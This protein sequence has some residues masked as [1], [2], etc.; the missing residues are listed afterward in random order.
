MRILKTLFVA[1]LLSFAA[2]AGAVDLQEGREYTV[3]DPPAPVDVKGKIEVI[4]FFSYACPHC[5]HLEPIIGP[6]VKKLPPDVAFRRVPLVG[7]PAWQPTAKLFYTFDAM[8]LEARYHGD[9]FVAIH[10]DHSMVP[11]DEKSIADWVAKKGID[12]G[13]FASTYGSF[14]VQTKVQQAQQILQSHHVSGVPAMVI[15]GRYLVRNEAINSYE[16]LMNLTDA[17]IAKVRAEQGGKSKGDK[18]K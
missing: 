12:S 18:K 10:G 8:G 14:A 17:V 16:D 4:E 7:G 15:D 3:I 11:T 2:A 13:K 1:F 6:W 9:V 5:N